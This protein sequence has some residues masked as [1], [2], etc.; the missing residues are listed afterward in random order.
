MT[1]AELFAHRSICYAAQ[2]L[3]Q[4]C[5]HWRQDWLRRR[6]FAA[7][8]TAAALSYEWIIADEPEHAEQVLTFPDACRVL[9]CHPV[10]VRDGIL[11][12]LDRVAMLWLGALCGAVEASRVSPAQGTADTRNRSQRE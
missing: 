12:P 7:L 8:F 2:S 3:L 1:I 9:C 4:W 5:A 11:A 10:D 6:D